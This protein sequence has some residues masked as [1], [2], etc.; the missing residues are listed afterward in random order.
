[1]E[2][3]PKVF[4]RLF[5]CRKKTRC[6]NILHGRLACARG[7]VLKFIHVVDN[8]TTFHDVHTHSCFQSLSPD[9]VLYLSL[10]SDTD[11][12]SVIGSRKRSTSYCDTKS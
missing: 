2:H 7:G 11:E 9:Q 4:V 10:P 5:Q 6:P 1:M 12:H 8:D 3:I